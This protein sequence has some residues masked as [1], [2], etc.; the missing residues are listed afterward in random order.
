VYGGIDAHASFEDIWRQIAVSHIQGEESSQYLLDRSLM[1]PR[2]LIELLRFC[3]SH[4]VN[5]RHNRIEEVDIDQG[6]EAYSSDLLNNINFELRDVLPTAD[7]LLYEF[8]GARELL[9]GTDVRAILLSKV[10]EDEWEKL[11]DLLLWY[12][13]FGVV[14]DDGETTYIY[15]VKYDIKRLRAHASRNDLGSV[16]FRINPAFWRALEI[17]H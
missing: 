2:A 3:K 6:E 7:D 17:Q 9:V 10:G 15:S 13:F 12:G 16:M 1:R 14:R 11:F 5:L 4:A 8:V